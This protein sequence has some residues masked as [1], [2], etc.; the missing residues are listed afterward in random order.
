MTR[1]L[2]IETSCDETSVAVVDDGRQVLCNLTATQFDLHAKYG[3]VVPEIASRAHIEKLDLLIREALTQSNTTID[4][5]DAIAVTRGPGLIGSLLVGVTAAKTIAWS[6][7]KP[8]VGVNHIHAHATSAAIDLDRHPWPAIALVVSG[9]HTS[10]YHVLSPL[11][12]RLLGGTIDDAAG[13]AFDKVASILQLGFPGGPIVDKRARRGRS[14][15]VRLPRSRLDPN[16]LDFS[17]SGLKTAVLYHVHG[18]GR[19]T[20]G[21]DRLT[22]S[23]LDDICASF[24]AAVIDVL[25]DKT[26][27]AVRQTG[28]GAV[29]VGGGVAA[30]SMLRDR[31]AVACAAGTGHAINR[32]KRQRSK[33]GRA[34]DTTP[35]ATPVDSSPTKAAEGPP[36]PIALHLTPMKYCTD[37]A[38][39]I[40]ALGYHLFVNGRRDDLSLSATANIAKL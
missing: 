33:S 2:G 23:D 13:E 28:V 27:L 30:N 35:V 5:I 9:G 8:L 31:L 36:G 24:S 6:W 39:M 17:F 15:A 3:G 10:L 18:P 22:E 19:T 25:V 37:N 1:I 14:D 40:A 20:G 34:S 11:D 16:S 32:E 26:M 21:F 38:A 7:T 4:E 12:V 29:V